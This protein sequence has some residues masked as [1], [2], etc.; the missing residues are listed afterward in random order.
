MGQASS[1]IMLV[2]PALAN[3]Q[4]HVACDWCTI[5]AAQMLSLAEP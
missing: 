5:L 2:Y 4:A 1:Q 3:V